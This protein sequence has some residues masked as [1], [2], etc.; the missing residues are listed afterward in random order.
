MFTQNTH[1]PILRN[2][3][4]SG[5]A[6]ALCLALFLHRNEFLPHY[7]PSSSIKPNPPSDY[8]P[9]TRTPIFGIEL[10]RFESRIGI[11][12]DKT[13]QLFPDE[14]NRTAIPAYVA[15]VGGASPLSGFAAKEQVGR[16]TKNTI[17]DLIS[18]IG[19]NFS[20]PRLRDDVQSLPYEIVERNN[21]PQIKVRGFWNE[22]LY[23]PEHVYSFIFRDLKRLAE[24]RLNETVQNVVLTV[25]TEAIKN[26]AA[27]AGLDVVRVLRESIAAGEAYWSGYDDVGREDPRRWQEDCILVFYHHGEAESYAVVM[28]YYLGVYEALAVVRG[29]D[30]HPDGDSK[31]ETIGISDKTEE[32]LPDF[33]NTVQKPLTA[34][35]ELEHCIPKLLNALLKTAKIEKQT[36]DRIFIT[37]DPSQVTLIEPKISAY[38]PDKQVISHP[39]IHSDEAIIRGVSIIANLLASQPDE[40]YPGVIDTTVLSLGIETAHGAFIKIFPQWS[41]I[42]DSKHR[43]FSTVRDNQEKVVINIY[44]GDRAVAS[45]NR[46]L[47]VL[48][49]AHLPLRPKGE[50]HIEVEFQVSASRGVIVQAKELENGREAKLVLPGTQMYMYTLEELDLLGKEAEERKEEDLQRLENARMEMELGEEA[51][52]FDVQLKV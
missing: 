50:L 23:T 39:D 19:R 36:V 16:N 7:L 29:S 2:L 34:P 47:G 6:A 51:M 10:G 24:K 11:F 43:L 25:P 20:D 32:S 44:E 52:R 33:Q 14:H 27:M 8:Y 40:C 5:I 9:E 4:L 41:V 22:K 15:F 1:M 31:T 13:L 3:S 48:E 42:P 45:K 21:T 38:F 30:V 12:R 26:A 18:I 37:G 49:L 35:T 28:D 46:F 17:Y